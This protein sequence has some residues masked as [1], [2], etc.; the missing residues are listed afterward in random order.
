MPN[1]EAKILLVDDDPDLLRLLAIRLKSGGYN[2]STAESGEQALA[3]I[4]ADLPQ[5]VISDLRMTGMDG[6]VLFDAIQRDHPA[7]PVIILTAHGT[8]PDAVSA[9]KR[10]VFGYLTKPY[11]AAAK[12][13]AAKNFLPALSIKRAVDE[14]IL[15]LP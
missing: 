11:E 5:L 8:I 7:L 6:I 4:A 10:G 1:T 2:V 15:L 9:T 13:A 14:S 3:A 12:A